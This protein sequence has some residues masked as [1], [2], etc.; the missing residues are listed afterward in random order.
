MAA[1]AV[2]SS[3]PSAPPP[4]SASGGSCSATSGS[5]GIASAGMYG[6]LDTT[7][8]KEPLCSGK[9]SLRSP[10]ISETPSGSRF[11]LA[12]AWAKVLNSTAWT[13]APGTSWAIEPAMAPEPVPRSTILGWDMPA[14]W[15]MTSWTTDSVSGPNEYA[16]PHPQFKMAEIRDAGD[17]LK[18]YAP[19]TLSHQFGVAFRGGRITKEH[20]PQPAQ[21][22][23]QQVLRKKFGI[24]ARGRDSGVG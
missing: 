18:R 8:S 21:P 16:G 1:A 15:S 24:D 23:A 20:R 5:F 13:S 19:G 10:R 6:G 9:A 14:T 3:M 7:T 2:G 22:H 11:L 4:Y 17:V 12:R